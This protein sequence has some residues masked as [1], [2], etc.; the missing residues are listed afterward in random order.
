MIDRVGEV[1]A[2]EVVDLVGGPG[3]DVA[4]VAGLPSARRPASRRGRI[5]ARGTRRRARR[6]RSARSPRRGRR[7]SDVADD[8]RRSRDGRR[9]CWPGRCRRW[10]SRHEPRRQQIQRATDRVIRPCLRPDEPQHGERQRPCHDAGIAAQIPPNAR[11]LSG[12]RMSPAGPRRIDWRDFCHM[13]VAEMRSRRVT[14]PAVR[15]RP[16]A[17][18]RRA[19][20]AERALIEG[21]E[22]GDDRQAEAGAGLGLVEPAA[23]RGRLLPLLGGQAR[24]VVVDAEGQAAGRLVVGRAVDS[25]PRPSTSRL[26]PF[27]GVVDEVADDLLEVLLL[28]LEARAVGH[29]GS[30]ASRPRSSWM[31]L[32]ARTSRATTGSTSVTAPMTLE[33]AAMRAR[34]R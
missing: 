1:A 22:V 11:I 29:V 24:P 5:R 3:D 9:R 30:R 2:V 7:R 18:D 28:A 6:A 34:S 15:P 19:V 32:I 23:A 20:E 8:G 26:R 14:P 10:C 13:S 4:V 17:A 33:R 12:P 16:E 25:R 21:D 31:R 27:A